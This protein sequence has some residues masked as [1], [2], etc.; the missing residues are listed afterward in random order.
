MSATRIKERSTTRSPADMIRYTILDEPLRGMSIH[1]V[2]DGSTSSCTI[3]D[4]PPQT[5]PEEIDRAIDNLLKLRQRLEEVPDRLGSSMIS[6]HVLRIAYAGYSHLNWVAFQNISP[7]VIAAAI[8]SDELQGAAA[9]SLCADQFIL[10]GD[11]NRE[12]SLDDLA[13]ALAQTAGPQQLCLLQRPDRD[14]DDASARFCSQLLRLLWQKRA[15]GREG[16]LEWLGGK[17][18]YT[19]CAFSTSLRSREFPTP[20]STISGAQVFPTI[21]MFRFVDQQGEDG[22]DEATDDVRQYQNY[23]AIVDTLLDAE[24]FAT[25]FLTYLRSLGSGLDPEKSILR[26]AHKG[27]SSS[28]SPDLSSVSPIPA[29]FFEDQ[30]PPNDPSRVVRPGDLRP[31]S[32]VVLVDSSADLTLG[33]SPTLSTSQGRSPSLSDDDTV[34]GVNSGA[35]LHYFFINIPHT[36]ADLALE[37]QQ[38]Q[39]R[40]SLA[41]TNHPEVVVVGGLTDFLRETAPGSNMA[42]W[43][44]RVEEAE[45][46]L[47]T[48]R[49]SLRIDTENRSIDIGVMAES[50]AR[51]LL[52]RFI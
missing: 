7:S 42:A 22:P 44:K 8:V 15:L 23:Y 38:Q 3:S 37:P 10:R 12:G 47:R 9:L 30:P 27:S 46:D 36:S 28:S 33:P 14:S 16:D 2:K 52:K 24:G 19:T 35:F 41:I 40:P 17:S 50:R 26:F 34:A 21:H 51:T 18:I 32:W 49:A 4:E 1:H 39:Q 31:G 20:S 43:E 29:G 11:D 45:E 48:R 6:S 25:R 13:I 5:V